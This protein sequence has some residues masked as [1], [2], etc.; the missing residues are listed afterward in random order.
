MKD[1]LQPAAGGTQPSGMD[2]SKPVN[3][4]SFYQT[5]GCYMVN[6]QSLQRCNG[7]LLIGKFSAPILGI[8]GDI[9]NALFVET[10]EGIYLYTDGS[11]VTQ[12]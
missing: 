4:D 1:T 3:P 5:R 9:R 8:H 2:D 12:L 10:T 11:P 7:K 6:D